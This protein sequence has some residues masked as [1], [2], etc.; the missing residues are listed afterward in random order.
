LG[1]QTVPGNV[2]V[3]RVRLLRRLCACLGVALVHKT[4]EGAP[5][6]M[7]VDFLPLAFVVGIA[8]VD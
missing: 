8:L 3:E 7:E 1:L 6:D 4:T 5:C 2:T